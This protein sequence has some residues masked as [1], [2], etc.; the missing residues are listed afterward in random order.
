MQWML[1]CVAFVVFI[2]TMAASESGC[3]DECNN[4]DV[5]FAVIAY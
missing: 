3:N 4:S 5:I 1:G 2:V